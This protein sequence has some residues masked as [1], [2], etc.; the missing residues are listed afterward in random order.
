MVNVVFF[1]NVLKYLPPLLFWGGAGWVRDLL[2]SSVL[3]VICISQCS[4]VDVECVANVVCLVEFLLC[5]KEMTA[6]A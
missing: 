2:F 5:M 4:C 1:L 3:I 6:V